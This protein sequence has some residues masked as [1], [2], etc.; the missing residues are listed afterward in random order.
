MSADIRSG[1]FL[2]DGLELPYR[3]ERRK[4]RR[5]VSVMMGV[6]EGLIVRAPLRFPIKD[7]EAVLRDEADWIRDKL[8][9]REDWLRLHPPLRI[10]GGE[11]IPLLGEEWKLEIRRDPARRRARVLAAEGRI[12]LELPRSAE[13]RTIL[14]GW[15]RR[16][17]RRVI[18]ARVRCWS[19]RIGVRPGRVTLRDTRSR[20]G[21]CSS[22]GDLSFS[23]RLVM[24][25][26][27]VLD[28]VI[29]HELCHIIQPD[30]SRRFWSMIARQSPDYERFRGWL[31]EN[32]E[33]LH[34]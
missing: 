15:M 34:F 10:A 2:L 3:L 27:D 30:H 29:A 1:F 22:S 16:L 6:R 20:W 14:S 28:Y 12:L 24:A 26:P 19:G 23:W 7:V 17:A 21:S 9:W 32:G 8:R 31:A 5:R 33:R 13:A 11:V 4:R 18:L 25:P